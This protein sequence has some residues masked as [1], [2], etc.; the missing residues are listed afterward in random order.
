MGI[1]RSKC[2]P[3]FI[4]TTP[5]GI[6]SSDKPGLSTTSFATTGLDK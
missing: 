2:K 3:A 5:L 4:F 1:L 6:A